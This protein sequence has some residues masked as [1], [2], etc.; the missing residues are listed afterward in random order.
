MDEALSKWRA[1]AK[2]MEQTRQL[3]TEARRQIERDDMAWRQRAY[4][5]ATDNVD[6]IVQKR[7]AEALRDIAPAFEVL[8]D[9]IAAR[10][11]A[12]R[13][14]HEKIRDLEL[15]L[16]RLETRLAELKTDRILN[17]APNAAAMLRAVN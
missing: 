3:E 2:A 12:L 16:A 6:A 1:E 5:Q 13:Q 9:A 11:E 7:I 10:D 17:A 15:Q 8:S 14:Q 4:A